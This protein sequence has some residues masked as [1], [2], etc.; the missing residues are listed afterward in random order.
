MFIKLQ[1]KVMAHFATLLIS[2]CTF[3]RPRLFVIQNENRHFITVGRKYLLLSISRSCRGPLLDDILMED[4]Q[5]LI[6]YPASYE[7]KL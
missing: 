6:E 1:A 3:M 7:I 2:T 5:M 4:K